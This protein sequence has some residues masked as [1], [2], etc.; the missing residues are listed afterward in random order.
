M[1]SRWQI[2]LPSDAAEERSGISLPLSPRQQP[3]ARLNHLALGPEAGRR[4]RSGEQRVVDLDVG[5]HANDP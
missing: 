4:H 1:R 2:A 3:Q 5:A